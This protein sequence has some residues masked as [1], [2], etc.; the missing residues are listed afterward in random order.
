[1]FVQISKEMQT[2]GERSALACATRIYR[3]GALYQGLNSGLVAMG[4]TMYTFFWS[5]HLVKGILLS[6]SG[7]V[8]KTLL[9][10][11]APFARSP[12]CLQEVLSPGLDFIAGS[13]SGAATAAASEV[14]RR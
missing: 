1:M 2:K 10:L 9:P 14:I 13:L 12:R 5:H 8:Q 3:Q 4:A 6:L 7:K 11:T